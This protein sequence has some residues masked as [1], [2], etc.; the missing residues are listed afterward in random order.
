MNRKIAA[1]ISFFSLIFVV[2]HSA[3]RSALVIGI[4]DYPEN[5]EFKDLSN[6]VA[7]AQLIA[8]T[9]RDVN[10]KVI[11]KL[12]VNQSELDFALEEFENEI[13]PGGTALV[14][15]AGHG[16]E[17]EGHNYLMTSNALLKAKSRLNEEAVKVDEIAA[18]MLVGGA[19]S[20]FL[21][22]DCCREH[23]G[24]GWAS[25][26]RRRTGL[27]KISADGDLII[28]TAASPGAVAYDGKKG[29]TPSDHEREKWMQ[30]GKGKG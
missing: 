17:H 20:S 6:C 18:S 30:T 22:L 16:I 8:A 9:L 5:S 26:G 25:R 15:F 2:S 27:A 12:N 23:P 13:Q 4:N 3:V 14:Y 21:L 7:E 11:E 10:F 28:S 19:S 29:N 24:A 1:L